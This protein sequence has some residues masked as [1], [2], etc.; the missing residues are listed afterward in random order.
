MNSKN[1]ISKFKSANSE[2]DGWC[3]TLF[4]LQRNSHITKM[5]N[6]K[7]MKLET[8]VIYHLWRAHSKFLVQV[9][10]FRDYK[11]GGKEFRKNK[12]Y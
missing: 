7:L 4:Y 9:T 6:V 8:Q 11:Y 10:L 2:R 1:Y 3:N 5:V 12:N